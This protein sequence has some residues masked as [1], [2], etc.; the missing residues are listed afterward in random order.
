MQTADK[1]PSISVPGSGKSGP[2]I[3]CIV[4]RRSIFGGDGPLNNTCEVVYL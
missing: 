1:R 2:I 4:M 3:A